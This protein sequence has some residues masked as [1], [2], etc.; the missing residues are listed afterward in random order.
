MSITA[1][2]TFHFILRDLSSSNLSAVRGCLAEKPD[3]KGAIKH[4]RRA[5]KKF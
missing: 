5:V 2:P 4:R 1:Q 3:D